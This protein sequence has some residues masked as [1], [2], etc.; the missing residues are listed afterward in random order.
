LQE[1]SHQI[2]FNPRSL[3]THYQAPKICNFDCRNKDISKI[4]TTPSTTVEDVF[5]SL[6]LLVASVVERMRE[7]RKGKEN[8]EN[9]TQTMHYKI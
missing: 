1:K 7:K 6:T 4:T 3:T 9:F 5:S 2:K 8:G